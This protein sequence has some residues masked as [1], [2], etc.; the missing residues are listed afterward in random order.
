[1]LN[2]AFFEKYCLPHFW[3]ISNSLNIFGERQNIT[4][5][6]SISLEQF[7]NSPSQDRTKSIDFQIKKPNCNVK[8]K[9]HQLKAAKHS[10]K[11]GNLRFYFVDS[12]V[13]G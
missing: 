13:A 10:S 8:L 12:F 6:L 11:S 1:M 9:M 3:R 4:N 5:I 2:G 7:Q